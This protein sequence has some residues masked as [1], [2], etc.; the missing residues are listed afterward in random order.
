MTAQWKVLH[1]LFR[2]SDY[3]KITMHHIIQSLT[4]F[5]FSF[6]FLN[7]PVVTQRL[8]C[9]L[10]ERGARP[11]SNSLEW[12]YNGVLL[13]IFLPTSLFGT[14]AVKNKTSYMMVDLDSLPSLF[15]HFLDLKAHTQCCSHCLSFSKGHI[16]TA[17]ALHW[18][19]TL[20][21]VTHKGESDR[22]RKAG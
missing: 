16:T 11:E 20:K 12:L 13:W 22:K 18:Q 8:C 10:S 2:Q 1:L 17:T 14:E 5:F 21:L 6:F 3:L 19:N 15:I 4:G 9:T 7:Q